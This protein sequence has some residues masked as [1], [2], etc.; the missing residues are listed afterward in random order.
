MKSSYQEFKQLP[1]ALLEK[2][3]ETEPAFTREKP[4][5]RYKMEIFKH[6]TV[7]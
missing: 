3:Q 7:R 4:R 2:P 1:L 6:G 5:D